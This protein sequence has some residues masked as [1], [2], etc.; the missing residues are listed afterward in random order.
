MQLCDGLLI[1]PRMQLTGSLLVGCLRPLIGCLQEA[2]VRGQGLVHEAVD[3][4]RGA[5]DDLGAGD[6]LRE[7]LVVAVVLTNPVVRL[8]GPAHATVGCTETEKLELCGLTQ[9]PRGRT[10]WRSALGSN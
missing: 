2:L 6:R 8:H 7:R 3:Q 9:R 1:G 10:G 4:C 5:A